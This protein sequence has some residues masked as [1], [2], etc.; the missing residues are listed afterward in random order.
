VCSTGGQLAA[1][2]AAAFPVMV[3]FKLGWRA[4][5]G[6]AMAWD[7][8]RARESAVDIGVCVSRG[9]QTGGPLVAAPAAAFPVTVR[10]QVDGQPNIH[11][12]ALEHLSANLVRNERLSPHCVI[13]CVRNG[14]R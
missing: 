5:A 8:L 4:R 9:F 3:R 1:A 7:V 10:S 2:P 13:Y 12:S 14:S 11:C 6:C